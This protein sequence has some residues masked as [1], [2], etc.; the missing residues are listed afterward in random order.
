LTISTSTPAA[1][2]YDGYIDV[3]MPK[4][5]KV[6]DGRPPMAVGIRYRFQLTYENEEKRDN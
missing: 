4:T 3:K 2:K 6:V 5:H 1:E